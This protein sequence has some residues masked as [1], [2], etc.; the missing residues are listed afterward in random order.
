MKYNNTLS[1]KQTIICGVPQG[2]VLGPLLFLLYINDIRNSSKIL[3]FILFADDT[4][5]FCSNKDIH[6]LTKTVNEELKKVSEWLKANKLSLNIKNS[7]TD[8]YSKKNKTFKQQVS[9]K[10]DDSNIKQVESARFLGVQIDSKLDWK[11]HIYK[12]CLQQNCQNNWYTLQSKTLFT[13]S[14]HARSILCIDISISK[15]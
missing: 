13:Q 2:S 11:Q 7:I 10:L 15:L 5:I 6:T 12:S 4:N 1:N 3:S 8:I 9:I 14:S